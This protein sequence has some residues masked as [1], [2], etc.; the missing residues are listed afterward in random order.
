MHATVYHDLGIAAWDCRIAGLSAAQAWQALQAGRRLL[1]PSQPTSVIAL[2]PL[3]L[4]AAAAPWRAIHD[5][6]GLVACGL[7]TSKGD[8]WAFTPLHAATAGPGHVGAAVARQLQ[9]GV[10]VPCAVAAACSTGLYSLLAGADW[11]ANGSCSRALVGAVDGSLP[12]WLQAGFARMGVLCTDGDPRAGEGGSSGFVTAAGAGVIAL[13]RGAAAWRL[14]AGVRLGDAGHE[15]H[16]VHPQTLT[17]A[18]TALWEVQPEPDLIVTHLTG[19][20]L[21]D[22]YELAGLD[23]G[24]WRHVPR[25]VLK[26]LIGHTLGASG[27]VELALALHSPARRMWK[28]SLGFG[29]HLAAVAVA[30]SRADQVTTPVRA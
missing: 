17:T 29:G 25:L 8:P 18:L 15:T 26:P 30:R 9:L 14:V 3:L 7:A 28:L 10:H 4:E 12:D 19:T 22:A 1:P 23:A 24:P 6:P 21:G 2:Q 13:V 20:A 16:F 27:A 5:Q 11:I